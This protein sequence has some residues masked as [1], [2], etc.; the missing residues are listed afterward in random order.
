MYDV[1]VWGGCHIGMK[2]YLIEQIKIEGSAEAES[3]QNLWCGECW[4][5]LMC[6]SQTVN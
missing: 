5:I 4:G 2:S 1:C 6:K 3:S